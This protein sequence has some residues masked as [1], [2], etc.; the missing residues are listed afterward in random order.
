MVNFR[1]KQRGLK[2]HY[3]STLNGL[4]VLKLC[5][6]DLALTDLLRITKGAGPTLIVDVEV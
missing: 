3:C 6:E 5:I 4:P 1:D 2:N